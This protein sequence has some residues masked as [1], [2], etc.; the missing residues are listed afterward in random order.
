MGKAY[1][2]G[3]SAGRSQGR[4]CFRCE[5]LQQPSLRPQWH[6]MPLEGADLGSFVGGEY[7]VGGDLRDWK[8]WGAEMRS[9]ESRVESGC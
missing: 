9:R 7:G 5:H 6:C 2:R 8:E 4:V 3:R 1:S